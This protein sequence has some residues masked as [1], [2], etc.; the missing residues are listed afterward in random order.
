[1]PQIPEAPLVLVDGSSYLFRAYH[2]LPPLT[3][4]SGQPTGAIYGVINMLRK[5][6]NDYKPAHIAVVF[7]CKEKTFRHEMYPDY[8]ANRTVM[9]DE[10]AVQIQ[11][12]HDL[13]RAMGLPLLA[14]PGVEADD[15]IGTLAK[16]ASEAG[17]YSIISTGDKDM[18]QLVNDQIILVNTMSD[19]ILDRNGVIAKFEV[20]PEQMIDY[21]SLIGDSVDNIPGVYKV[22]PKT[23]VKWL[24]TYKSLDNIIANAHEITGKIG[25]NLRAAIKDLPIFKELIKIKTDVKLDITAQ[26]LKKNSADLSKLKAMYAELEFRTWF[27]QISEEEVSQSPVN[28]SIAAIVTSQRHSEY[29]LVLEKNEFDAWIKKLQNA[30]VFAFDTETT[31][32]NYMDAKLVGVS[33]AVDSSSAAYVPVGHDYL[34]VP[35]QLPLDYVLNSL[36]PMLED[37]KQIKVCHHLKYDL[38]VLMNYGIVMRGLNFDTMLASYVL[39][40]VASRH[41]MSELAAIH[42][43]RPT[44]AYEDVAGKGAKQINFSEVDLE[45]AAEYACEDADVTLDLYQV[46]AKRLAESPRQEYVF[47]A[48]E[49][50]LVPVLATMEM[51]GVLLDIPALQRQSKDLAQSI[52]KLEEEAYTLAGSEFNLGSPKQL[53]EIL[54]NKLQLPIIEK[55]PTGQPSTGEA[56]LQELAEN[57]L[58]PKV[59]LEYRSL[60][61]LKSTYTDKL[62][63]Q[64]NQRTGRVHTS[65]Q[66]AVTATGRLSSVDPNLQNIPIRTV[67]GKKIR[68]A[69]IA[70]PGYKIVSADY[71]QIELRIMAHLSQDV[72]LLH[73]FAQNQDVHRATAA[74]VFGITQQQVTE[75]QRRHAKAINFGLI[76][77]MSA[78]GLSKQL[79]IDRS[80]ADHYIDM[81]FKRFPGV[82][83]YMENTRHTAAANGYVETLF[84]RRLYLPDI[85]SSKQMLR[86]AAERAAINAPLQGAQSDIIKLAMIKVHDWLQK[87][88]TDAA[89]I[90]QVHDELVFEIPETKVAEYS[91]RIVDIMMHTTEL[92]INLEVGIGIGNNWDEAH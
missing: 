56:V 12:L 25:E 20:T 72:A 55:T 78:F 44:I 6:L 49:L 22:G 3:N 59:I 30:S 77:G 17:L 88:A 89:M 84:G 61:K 62:P 51:H 24:Q 5:L 29:Q 73:T 76:Y 23:A 91:K 41:N 8:K 81:Y 18:A 50:P 42:L 80:E 10:L 54:F 4:S 2:A 60:S 67:E 28:D 39:N 43:K 85:R 53:Q 92:S 64:V 86:K 33:F 31:S 46:F 75:D 63:L 87:E 57:Y 16:Q 45:K 83:N 82:K 90:M 65:Y 34:D 14:I 52:Q 74:E 19:S 27:K 1:M 26:Q 70:P 13:I 79:G 37:P 35:Q 11:P 66:Q 71:S 58:L 48:I 47:K 38:E 68:A 69:F 7:D 40:S 36:K 15:V 32:L 9:P 21:L